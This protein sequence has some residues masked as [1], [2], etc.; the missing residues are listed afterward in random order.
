[1]TEQ[2]KHTAWSA[3][4]NADNPASAEDQEAARARYGWVCNWTGAWCP[5][6]CGSPC[7]YRID[8]TLCGGGIIEN[9]FNRAAIAK[10]KG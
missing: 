5:S 2:A 10:A 7:T 1:M 6:G 9:D 3:E 8:S 4:Y